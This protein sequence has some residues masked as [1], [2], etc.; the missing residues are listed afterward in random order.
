MSTKKADDHLHGV[1]D[2]ALAFI[3]A[4]D[5]ASE[6]ATYLGRQHTAHGAAENE[7]AAAAPAESQA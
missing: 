2:R 6:F 3:H 4:H 7:R 1:A 5:L